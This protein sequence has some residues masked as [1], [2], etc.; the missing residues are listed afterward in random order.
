[1]AETSYQGAFG[2]NRWR[3]FRAACRSMS[4]FYAYPWLSQLQVK[5]INMLITIIFVINNNVKTFFHIISHYIMHT[6]IFNEVQP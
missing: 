6:F 5:L 2:V 1:M 3:F 4:L